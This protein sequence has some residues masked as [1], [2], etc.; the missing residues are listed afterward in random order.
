MS[1]HNS[2]ASEVSP[3]G[4]QS[5]QGSCRT[6]LLPMFHGKRSPVIWRLSW[7]AVFRLFFASRFVVSDRQN[8]A[9]DQVREPLPLF[10]G[11]HRVDSLKGTRERVANFR[12]AL[13][14]AIAGTRP[15]PRQTSRPPP[16]RQTPPALG[17]HPFRPEPARS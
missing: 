13:D 10:R 11:Q 14:A 17:G 12:G 16:H 4:L 15:W 6:V 7:L 1:F 9:T 5:D 8:A 2:C 3:S